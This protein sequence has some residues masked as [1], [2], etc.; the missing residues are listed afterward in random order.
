MT[1]VQVSSGNLNGT[2]MFD[3]SNVSRVESNNFGLNL[4]FTTEC[5]ISTIFCDNK[6]RFVDAI[7]KQRAVDLLKNMVHSTRDNNLSEEVK[8]MAFSALNGEDNIQSLEKQVEEAIDAIDFDFSDLDTP[9]LPC[10]NTSPVK[11]SGI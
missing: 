2:Q 6:E 11:I 7:G 8:S 10:N 4:S 3:L 9:C 5:D 1:P